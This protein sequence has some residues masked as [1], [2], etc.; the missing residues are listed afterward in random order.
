[1]SPALQVTSLPAEP[2]EKP[3]TACGM[4]KCINHDCYITNSEASLVAQTV[5]YLPAMLETRVQCLG[6]EDP[7]KGMPAHFSILAWRIPW[8]EEPDQL[9]VPWGHIVGHD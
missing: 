4:N 8:T 9:S 2:L 3:F 6:Q 1:M 5:K 7:L